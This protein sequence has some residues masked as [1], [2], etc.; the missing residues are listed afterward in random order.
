MGV[1]SKIKD[2][3]E[4]KNEWTLF[5]VK[6]E[7]YLTKCMLPHLRL[8]IKKIPWTYMT[9]KEIQIKLSEPRIVTVCTWAGTKNILRK[10]MKKP[11]A[12]KDENRISSWKI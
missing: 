11:V 5:Y 7:G 6:I 12:W 1:V 2:K 4:C 3:S 10:I 9:Q 8:Q